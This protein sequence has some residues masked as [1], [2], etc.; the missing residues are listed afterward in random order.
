M[1]LVMQMTLI[2]VVDMYMI[3]DFLTSFEMGSFTFINNESM[4]ASIDEDKP[5]AKNCVAQN[6]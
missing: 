3:N 1:L 5:Q 4:K 6:V 2:Q